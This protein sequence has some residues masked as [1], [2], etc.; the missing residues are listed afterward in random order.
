MQL[1]K[2]DFA[3][4]QHLQKDCLTPLRELADLV[5]LS[6]ASVQRRIQK[7]RDSG[8]I[9]GNNAVLDPDKLGQVVTIFVEVRVNQTHVTDLDVLKASF[10]I[11]EVQQC[12]YVTGEADFMLVLL[13][14]SMSRFQALCDQ[15]FHQNANVQWFKTTVVLER[16][17]ATL[18][19]PF[20]S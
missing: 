18:D 4:L 3:L 2:F 11:P 8:Y 10:S 9:I 7:L 5:H 16:I 14:P 13:V 20:Q 19:V 1:D 15:L 17:K 6:T 12:Y